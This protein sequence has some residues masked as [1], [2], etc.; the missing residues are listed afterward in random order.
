MIQSM[1]QIRIA[2]LGLGGLLLVLAG[3]SLAFVVGYRLRDGEVVRLEQQ[4]QLAVADARVA[5]L[6]QGSSQ[7]AAI[8]LEGQVAELQAA[9][10]QSA[11]ELGAVDA[12][13]S[14]LR[15]ATV[16]SDRTSA[17]VEQLGRDYGELLAERDALL[18]RWSQ[19]IP[20]DS[21]ELSGAPLLLD[22]GV[23]DVVALR[24]VCTGSMEPNITCDDLLVL[25][26]PSTLSDIDRGDIIYFRKPA[27][28]CAG[29]VPGIFVLHRVVDV[30]TRSGDIF[31][32]TQGDAMAGPDRC[33]VPRA[34][35]IYKLLTNI[36]GSRIAD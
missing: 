24:A 16:A 14:A 23:D 9:L 36:R 25:Y 8:Q 20:I 2:A 33:L 17:A 34:D 15:E 12:A 22:R 30:M 27:A 3:L 4:L 6:E 1:K 31:F 29:S 11:R 19:V 13:L 26:A 28:D 18:T 7:G 10:D 32:Q 21:P 35:V 5:S